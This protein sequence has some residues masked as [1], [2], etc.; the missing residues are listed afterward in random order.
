MYQIKCDDYILFDLRDEDLIVNN[1]KLKLESNKVGELTFTIYDTHPYFEKIKKLKSIIRVYQF[2]KS[3]SVDGKVIFKGRV[4]EDTQD[5]DNAK[6][7]ECE[8]KLAMLIDSQTPPFELEKGTLTSTDIAVNTE[9]A[10]LDES[11]KTTEAE[12]AAL[13]KEIEATTDESKKKE[14]NTQLEEL[15]TQLTDLNSKADELINNGLAMYSGNTT[16]A[17]IFKWLVGQH[18]AQVEDWQQFELDETEI[19]VDY[20]IG[21]EKETRT[22]PKYCTVIDAN[23]T[24]TRSNKSYDT[25]F[26]T[27]SSKLID[28]L[29][30]YV[31]VKY[32]VEKDGKLVDYIEYVHDFTDT[33]TQTIE[34]GE[35]LLDI[36]QVINGADVATVIIPLGKS[37]GESE[38]GLTITGI[39]DGTYNDTGDLD[40]DGDI[41]KKDDRIWSK[42]AVEKY[43][44]ITKVV[45][46][47]EVT[48]ENSLFKKA[49]AK[50]KNESI[51]LS[52]T[53]TLKAVD[54][55]LINKDVESF[56]WQDKIKVFSRPHNI[57]A[58]NNDSVGA[59]YLLEKLEV[60][61]LE[62]QN[63]EIVLGK[64]WRT[65]TDVALG[66]GRTANNAL[67]VTNNITAD[68][69]TNEQV[70]GIVDEKIGG[71][72][73][74]VIESAI[75]NTSIIAQTAEEIIFEVV[76]NY[77]EKTGYEEYK[78]DV[79]T[80][81]QLMADEMVLKFNTAIA[82]IENVDGN[83]QT[84]LQEISRYI[85]FVDGKI[86]L[87]EVGNEITLE[88]SNNRLSFL[89]N[90]LEVAYMSNNKLFVTNSE[91]LQNLKI[92]NFAFT[93]R[94]NGNLSL[95]L[96]TATT[97]EVEDEDTGTE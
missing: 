92:G 33:A 57:H 88:I 8:S 70:Q 4:I 72:I 40:D 90:N 66:A 31:N 45:D 64:T 34:L 95:K 94:S 53:I 9:V 80:T 91:F 96:S 87:G 10:A 25:T 49:I 11:I 2:K 26:N 6:K 78:E 81:L 85:R 29:G 68:Y 21:G 63:T 44:K 46:F 48:M 15:N 16:P 86:V 55:A 32:D 65:L 1:P 62:P 18:N 84:Q 97:P 22:V 42:E 37:E 60:D 3:P 82:E 58:E 17:A 89:Q 56:Y 24:I 20:I 83:V 50:L 54:L 36:E 19:N 7:I 47:N 59:T 12:I 39:A 51:Y 28:M 23:D 75:E 74:A 71:E 30:G 38:S 27:I 52:A 13:E 79:S 76:Q 93:P 5:F 73:D 61:L 43:G 41:V 14:L 77:V 67:T 35:N 69:T